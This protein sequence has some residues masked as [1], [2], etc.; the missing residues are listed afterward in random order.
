MTEHQ[1]KRNPNRC[2]SHPGAVLTDILPATGR[3]KSEIAGLLGISRQH[4][5]DITSGKKPVSPQMAV[6]FSKLLGGGAEMWLRL[7][8]AYDLWHA[9]RETDVSH[10]RPLK[11]A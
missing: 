7:Q 2:P 6:R 11:V 10:I 8:V 1:A 3:T 5:H 9:E 4:L